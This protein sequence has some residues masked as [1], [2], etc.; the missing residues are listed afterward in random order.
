MTGPGLERTEPDG[1]SRGVVLMLHGGAKTGTQPV[2][3]RSGS[4]WRSR[5][6]R[7]EIADAVLSAGHSLWLLRFAVRGWNAARSAEP[8]PLADVRWA[9][10]QADEHHPG[11]LVA[12]LGHSMGARA[13]VHVADHPSVAG[14]VALAPWWEP[15]D[16]VQPLAG[17]HLVAAHG[18]RDRITSARMTRAYVERARPVAT[19]SEF[20]D[21]GPL[22]HY[23]LRSPETWNAFALESVLQVLD[24][25]GRRDFPVGGEGHRPGS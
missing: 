18:S 12:L 1:P 25:Q 6:M 17:R 24:R 5:R 8:S 19:S 11:R 3:G 9:L 20:V 10:A 4:Y 22:G 13:A 14:V 16:P 23:L 2:G 15:S 21:V 7:D